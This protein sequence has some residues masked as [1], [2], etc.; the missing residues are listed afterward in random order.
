MCE[1]VVAAYRENPQIH[2]TDYLYALRIVT[3]SRDYVEKSEYQ[4]INDIF[5]SYLNDMDS[6]TVDEKLRRLIAYKKSR[7]LLRPEDNEP[8]KWDDVKTSIFDVDIDTLDDESFEMWCDFDQPDANKRVEKT[9]R[10]FQ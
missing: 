10:A 2:S 5:A 7:S 1:K 4:E 9:F 8:R 6:V 3:Q